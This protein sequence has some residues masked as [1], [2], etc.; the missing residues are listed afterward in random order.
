L[1][2]RWRAPNFDFLLVRNLRSV[3]LYV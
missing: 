3:L 2:S 1:F